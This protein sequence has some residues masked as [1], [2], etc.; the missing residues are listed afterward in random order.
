M[1]SIFKRKCFGVEIST[2]AVDMNFDTLGV[3]MKGDNVIRGDLAAL[4][5]GYL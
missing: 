4:N 5:K 2:N 3:M 1:L